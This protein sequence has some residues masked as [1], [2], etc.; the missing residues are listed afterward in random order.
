MATQGSAATGIPTT[1]SVL[2]IYERG[3]RGQPD[4]LVETRYLAGE[5]TAADLAVGAAQYVVVRAPTE[6]E[7]KTIDNWAQT[8]P[9]PQPDEA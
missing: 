7:A 9:Q 5:P 3:G 6:D 2:E 1:A 4:V 8:P